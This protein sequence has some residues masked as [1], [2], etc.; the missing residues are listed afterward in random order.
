MIDVH[1]HL[2]PGLDDGARDLHNALSL[3]YQLVQAGFQKVIATPHVF[4]G[5]N[6]LSPEIIRESVAFLNLELKG[7]GLPL[8]VL[9]GAEYYIF[10]ELPEY[11]KKEKLLTLADSQKYLLIELP[12]HQLPLYSSQVIFQLQ[13]QGITP[14]LAHP[15]R[16]SYFFEAREFLLQWEKNGVLLQIDLGSL[17]GVYGTKAFK[18]A[19]WLL[20]KGLV[21]LIGT[22]AHRPSK[23]DDSYKKTLQGLLQRF[24]SQQFKHYFKIR[25]QAILS[26]ANFNPALG[27]KCNS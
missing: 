19:N 15:E 11:L 14:V 10:P 8:K 16:Y 12:M 25:P 24:G 13:T 1:C 20:K 3:A 27:K 23:N 7:N 18:M 21:H 2:L 22:D 5:R 26:G 6:F 17:K 9:P 4:E